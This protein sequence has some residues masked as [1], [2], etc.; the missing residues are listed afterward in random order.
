VRGRDETGALRAAGALM[1]ALGALLAVVR[2]EHSWSEF[3]QFVAFAL[4]AVLL[5]ALAVSGADGAAERDRAESWRG[6]LVV[7]SVLLS[8]LALFQFLSWVGAET[9]HL[10]DD[11]AVLVVTALIATAG[12]RRTRAPYAM[13]LAAFA[14]LGAWMLVWIKVFPDPSGDTVR[15]LLLGGG[16]AV[17][18]VAALADLAGAIGAGEIATAGALGVVAA[19]ILGVFLSAFGALFGGLDTIL[20]GH[21]ARGEAGHVAGGTQEAA[22]AVFGGHVSGS[23]TTG[24]DIYLLLVSL[25]LIVAGAPSGGVGPSYVGVFFIPLFFSSTAAQLASVSAGHAPSHSLLGWPL[26]LLLAG[27]ACLAAPLLRRRPA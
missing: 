10:L 23:Q 4:P 11:A 6:V 16:V 19:G 24:W 15:W 22:P 5:F 27:L 17:L 3:E 25:V 2:R 14:L 8:L 12:A 7:V 26:V 18:V 1:L 13:L 21:S 9:R 20:A